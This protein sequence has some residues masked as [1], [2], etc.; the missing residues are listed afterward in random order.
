[1]PDPAEPRFRPQQPAR[2]PSW[3]HVLL[4][5]PAFHI[6]RGFPP[7]ALH[8]LNQIGAQKRHIERRGNIQTVKA[9]QRVPMAFQRHGGRRIP[10]ADEVQQFIECLLSGL[11]SLCFPQPSEMD[12]EIRP[13]PLAQL[14]A[15]AGLC[16][17]EA[18]LLNRPTSSAPPLR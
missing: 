9:Q 12:V 6:A 15:Q 16:V 5:V 8:I 13:V 4:L 17:H 11:P 14:V 3:Y 10:P 7:V 1:M 18:F 2:H